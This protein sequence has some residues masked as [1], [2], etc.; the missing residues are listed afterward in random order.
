M[1]ILIRTYP[2]FFKELLPKHTMLW[3]TIGTLHYLTGCYQHK[4][5]SA[6]DLRDWTDL[7]RETKRMIYCRFGSTAHFISSPLCFA[8]L[9]SRSSANILNSSP[10]RCVTVMG[11]G[12]RGGT[13]GDQEPNWDEGGQ[14]RN[15]VHPL[16]SDSSDRP[17]DLLEQRATGRRWPSV[18]VGKG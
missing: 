16:E 11:E 1:Y 2:H 17:G 7:S 10:L 12:G 5:S 18:Q 4:T 3:M 15:P 14:R 6:H 9:L 8:W 13:R